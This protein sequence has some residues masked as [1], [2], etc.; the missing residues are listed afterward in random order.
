MVSEVQKEKARL[1]FQASERGRAPASSMTI[2][3]R[4]SLDIFA[5]KMAAQYAD[6]LRRSDDASY[7]EDL[8]DEAQQ[9]ITEAEE[10]LYIL[11]IF[12]R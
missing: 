11:A 3:E 6:F 10:L 2:M 12:D 7:P 1:R 4:M 5:A 8:A 9:A